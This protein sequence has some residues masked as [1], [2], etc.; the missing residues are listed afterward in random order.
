MATIFSVEDVPPII[1]YTGT[2]DQYIYVYPFVILSEQDIQVE[3]DDLTLTLNIDYT[4]TGVG[5]NGGGTVVLIIPSVGGELIQIFRDTKIER[6]TDYVE[7]GDFLAETV[8]NDFDRIILMLQERA[9]FSLRLDGL[10]MM[11]ADLDMNNFRIT[12][13]SDPIDDLDAVNLQT[14]NAFLLDEDG[15]LLLVERAETAADEAEESAEETSILYNDFRD[16]YMGN[17]PNF[18]TPRKEGSLFYYDG[19]SFTQGLYIY[20]SSNNDPITG[21]WDLVSGP[22]VQGPQGEQGIQ[23][24][25][26]IQGE[27]GIQ[28]VQG[29]Q[30]IQGIQGSI[31]DTGPQ[32]VKGETGSQ[33]QQGEQG[34]E[35]PEGPDGPQGVQGIQGSTGS[36]G[37]QGIQGETGND[38]TSFQIDAYGTLIER[39]LYDDEPAGFTYYATDYQVAEDAPPSY[40]R[41]SGDGLTTSYLLSYVPDGPQSLQ[42]KVGGVVQAPD[43]YTVIIGTDPD[44]YTIQFLLA[45]QSGLE[46]VVREFTISTGYGAIFIKN[47]ISSADWGDAIPF[48]KG[49]R[50]DQGPQG[51]EGIQG[52]QGD[53]GE[54]GITGAQGQ[55]GIQGLVGPQGLEGDVGP[56]GAQGLTGDRGPDGVQGLQGDQ[57]VQGIQGDQGITGASGPQGSQGIQGDKGETG[58]NGA[59]GPTGAQGPDGEQGQAGTDGTDGTDGADGR[60]S[61]GSLRVVNPVVLSAGVSDLSFDSFQ[62]TGTQAFD[63]WVKLSGLYVFGL[64]VGTG[65]TGY[66]SVE[67]DGSRVPGD[68]ENQT[69]FSTENPN[70]QWMPYIYVFVAANTT[71]VIEI[72]INDGGFLSGTQQV[73]LRGSAFDDRYL[74]ELIPVSQEIT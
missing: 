72:F 33:G 5:E 43:M 47:S 63:R 40:D 18:P 60:A 50:G 14:L 21:Q 37:I 45:P 42:V 12:R 56:Q 3:I 41:F 19:T 59:T 57:G 8:N 16:D 64:N 9:A 68:G 23:G 2:V 11:A 74:V 1:E 36:Q 31:G 6:D 27:Q 22:G 17:G 53:Q 15:V 39:D 32:G 51:A 7:N 58:Q 29:E 52:P 67:I 70:Y 73:G 46:I 61:S 65:V 34:I 35:G 66:V 38:G 25:T 48:G 4:V 13:L 44:S 26:G 24:S 55:Q 71:P 20:Y 49:P 10:N 30:G 69:I 54:I 62:V 28:G